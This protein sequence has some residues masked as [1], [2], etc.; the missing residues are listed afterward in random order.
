MKIIIVN[1]RSKK[2]K[3]NNPIPAE[4]LY[5]A[6][7]AFVPQ[8][9]F[10]KKVYNEQYIISTK[11]G[12]I[13]FSQPIEYYDKVLFTTGKGHNK[14]KTKGD[15]TKE[16]KQ[17]W[18]NQI[19]SKINSL[20]KNNKIERIDLH[21]T[22]SYWNVIKDEFENNPRI[23]FVGQQRNSPIVKNKY[24]QA[25][26]L[27]NGSNLDKCLNLISTIEGE[28]EEIE[29]FFY[30]SEDGELFGKARDVWK[31][32]PYVD[33]GGLH[34]VSMNRAKQ[35]RGWVIDQNYLPQLEKQEGFKQY[36]LK[37]QQ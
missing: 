18:V 37:K 7:Y 30:H 16:E 24:E 29:K 19:K 4:E 25:I 23:K 15:W 32:F 28:E 17:L 34:R 31:K 1:C 21:L 6:S 36:R 33:L 5:S 22:T 14:L 8:R 26:K 20:L 10:A 9:D 35:H 27:Y 3:T 11:Y 2:I 13:S 12:L